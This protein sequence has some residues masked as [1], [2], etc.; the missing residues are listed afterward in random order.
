MNILVAD[1]HSIVREGLKQILQR[2]PYITRVDEAADTAE[3]LAKIRKHE[4]AVVVLDIAMPGKS[5]FDALKEIKMEHPRIPVLILSMYPESQFAVRA[6]R[7][8]AAGYMTKDSAPEELV[9]AI[10]TLLKGRKY[11]SSSLAEE[12]ASRLDKG[13]DKPLHETLSDREYQVLRMISSGKSIAEIADAM[14][15]SVKTVS[16]YKRRIL[17]KMNMNTTAEIIGYAIQKGLVD[18]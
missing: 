3:A 13:D 12:L 10:Q 11:I 1:D 4:Y 16:T 17:D 18:Q 15:L 14:F 2:I 9:T 5:G 7:A 8:G 6:F